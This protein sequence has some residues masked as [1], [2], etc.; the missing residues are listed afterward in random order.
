MRSSSN[1]IK[2]NIVSCIAIAASVVAFLLQVIGAFAFCGTTD[3]GL[4]LRILENGMVIA[5]FVLVVLSLAASLEELIRT[6]AVKADNTAAILALE[7]A[8]TMLI[9]SLLFLVVF[10]AWDL[11]VNL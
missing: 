3:V 5:G 10:A 9:A 11:I 2:S 1:F 8:C 4:N 7:V 6:K